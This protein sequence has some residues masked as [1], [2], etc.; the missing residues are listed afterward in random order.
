M[1]FFIHIQNLICSKAQ[2][3]QFASESLPCVSLCMLGSQF[4]TEMMQ[5]VYGS[6]LP[7]D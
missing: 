3:Y 6:F 2:Y 5:G 4:G 7:A 1:Y